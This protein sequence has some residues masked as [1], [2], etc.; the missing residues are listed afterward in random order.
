[1]PLPQTGLPPQG[2]CR[3]PPPRRLALGSSDW[4]TGCAMVR[5]T[6]GGCLPG[7]AVIRPVRVLVLTGG[8]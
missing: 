6:E 4:A 2:L 1:M 5:L 7:G 3:S 8:H